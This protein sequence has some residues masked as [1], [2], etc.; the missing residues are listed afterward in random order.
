METNNTAGAAP[1]APITRTVTVTTRHSADCADKDKGSNW[2][3]CRCRKALLIYEGEGSGTNRRVSA[4]TRSWAEAEKRAQEWRDK[5]DPTKQELKRLRAAKE[6][7]Q[8]RVEAA[9]ALYISDMATRLGD[10]GTC[11][12]ARSL[13]GNVDPTTYDVKRGGRLFDW[14]DTI[15]GPARPQYIADFTPAHLTAWRSSWHFGSDLTGANRWSMVK[16]FFHFCEAQGWISDNPARKLKRMTVERGN[17]TAI[18][19]DEQYRKILDA[20]PLYQPDN[21]PAATGKAWQRRLLIFIELLRWSGM[22]LVDGIQ[23]QPDSV[24]AD[25]V[26]RYRR[27]KTGELATV[28]LPDHVVAL[29]AD[30]PLERDSVGAGQPFRSRDLAIASDCAKWHRRVSAVFGLAG[31]RT[32]RTEMGRQRDPHPHML[33]DT[34]AVWHLRHGAR[35]HTVAK[36]LGHAKTTTTERAYLPWVKELEEAHIADARRS[37][38]AAAP[39]VKGKRR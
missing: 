17:R 37:L 6:S 3:R 28:P 24:S 12:M 39:P 29:L 7:K 2:S 30:I 32:V 38:A 13:L 34:F 36:M 5:W 21:V 8:V 25:G 26:L 14:L 19:T 16:G 23:F 1:A 35:L 22:A 27:Q 4:K 20:V 33:R 15:P 9:V 31:I 18:F 10:N 11:A